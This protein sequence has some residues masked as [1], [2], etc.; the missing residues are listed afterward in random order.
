MKLNKKM[1][2][3]MFLL[4]ALPVVYGDS[5]PYLPSL[6]ISAKIKLNFS[7]SLDVNQKIYYSLIDLANNEEKVKFQPLENNTITIPM[8]NNRVINSDFR[9]ISSTIYQS[10]NIKPGNNDKLAK[11]KLIIY[12]LKYANY[13][14]SL[15]LYIEFLDDSYINRYYIKEAS[16][17]FVSGSIT[18]SYNTNLYINTQLSGVFSFYNA[19]TNYYIISN[20]GQK[21]SRKSNVSCDSMKSFGGIGE[22]VNMTPQK[23][24]TLNFD[25]NLQPVL[26][27]AINPDSAGNEQYIQQFP[28]TQGGKD[29]P[30]KFEITDEPQKCDG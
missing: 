3:I 1:Q 5:D 4:G 12:G 16:S 25:L 20:D 30:Y 21:K 8:M 29:Y 11:Y 15:P 19:V 22:G 18:D 28:L 24:L 9:S 26:Q 23:K 13:D 2:M 14:I 6:E 17:D 7:Q 10:G 27:N